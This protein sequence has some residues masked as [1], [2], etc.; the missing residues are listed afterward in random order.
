MLLGDRVG[1]VQLAAQRRA[2][3]ALDLLRR[4]VRRARCR[5][6]ARARTARWSS[7]R[8][9]PR[10]ANHSTCV[11]PWP[12][13]SAR[14]PAAA[15]P[16]RQR[17]APDARDVLGGQP[18]AGALGRHLERDQHLVDERPARASPGLSCGRSA[19]LMRVGRRE[20]AASASSTPPCAGSPARASTRCASPASPPTRASRRRSSTTTSTRARR[21]WS[22]RSSTPTSCAGDVRIARRRGRR[23]PAAERLE[24]MIDACL[25]APGAQR[26]DWLLWVELWLRA[27]R[28]PGAARD[29]R[30]A[31]RALHEWFARGARRGRRGRRLRRVDVAPRADRLLALIDGYGIRVLI[32]DPAMP[33]ERARARDLGR[34][35]ARARPSAALTGP[36]PRARPREQPRPPAVVLEDQ[37][38][39]RVHDDLAL[40][41]VVIVSSVRDARAARAPPARSARRPGRPRARS[42]A[43]EVDRRPVRA[44]I[45]GRPSRVAPSQP[46][47]APPPGRR[48]ARRGARRRPRRGRARRIASRSSN[49]GRRGGARGRSGVAGARS[50]S[51]A[52]T[53]RRAHAPARSAA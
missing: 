12:P 5:P 10:R 50:P 31:V 7:A 3:V 4:P 14:V 32:G 46:R 1:V 45:G 6:S 20:R 28:Q 22:R 52:S 2:Q 13:C 8:T 30:A 29:R 42:G 38:R 18:P 35:R 15:Q 36:A 25:P 33:R 11:Q 44:P 48:A 24:A 17:L 19:C 43:A 47:R 53:I 27:G 21:C 34:G 16:A 26:D 41:A 40:A 9:A 39:L 23:D 51:S 37:R 49:G